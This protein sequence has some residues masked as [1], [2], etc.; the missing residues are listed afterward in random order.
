MENLHRPEGREPRHSL[1]WTEGML[2]CWAWSGGGDLGMSLCSS[3]VQRDHRLHFLERDSPV[4]GGSGSA[5]RATVSSHDVRACTYEPYLQQYAAFFFFFERVREI[6]AVAAT[7]S[8][9]ANFYATHSVLPSSNLDHWA[10]VTSKQRTYIERS[11]IRVSTT[12]PGR[13]T[14]SYLK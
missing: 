2:R 8:P 7:Y 9:V 13:S 14:I 11:G 3:I 12:H 6:A 1:V 4:S 5:R 10:P